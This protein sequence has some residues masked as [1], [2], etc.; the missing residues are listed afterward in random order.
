[1]LIARNLAFYMAFYC[2]GVIYI[3]AAMVV[4]FVHEAT[5]QR[6]GSLHLFRQ[7]GYDQTHRVETCL[8]K[9]V[10]KWGPARGIGQI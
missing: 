6:I 4:M 10:E 8:E 5:L 3:L 2:G 7:P 9:T 1:M